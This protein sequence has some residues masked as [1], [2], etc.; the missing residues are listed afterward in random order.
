MGAAWA[1]V[2]DLEARWRGLSGTEQARAETLL[3]D[4]QA[5]AEATCPRWR[6]APE[7]A[8]TVVVCAMVKRA[9]LAEMDEGEGEARGIVA[10]ETHTTGP[11][12]DAF[13]YSNPEGGIFMR[14]AEIKLLGGQGRT[15]FEVDLLA[16]AAP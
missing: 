15:A 11:F 3:G 4:A 9:M 16:G 2:A 12:S 1:T 8:R 7:R 5:Y 10:S 14:G 6:D 13:T